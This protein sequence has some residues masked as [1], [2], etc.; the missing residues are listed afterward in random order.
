MDKLLQRKIHAPECVLFPGFLEPANAPS[1]YM[2]H[3][4]ISFGLLGSPLKMESSHVH[5]DIP[6]PSLSIWYIR[7]AQQGSLSTSVI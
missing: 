7:D 5:L 4:T 2:S 1:K 6:S 3:S